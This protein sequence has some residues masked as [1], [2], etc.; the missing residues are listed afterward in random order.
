MEEK[1]I[2]RTHEADA[3]NRFTY[4]SLAVMGVPIPD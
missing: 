1:T 2:E 3:Y 4:F